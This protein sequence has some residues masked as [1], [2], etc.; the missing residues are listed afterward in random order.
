MKV[1]LLF[2]A[3]LVLDIASKCHIVA[4]MTEG[5][6]IPVV[7]GVFH[8]TYILNA[9][10]AFGILENQRAVFIGAASLLLIMFA[11]FFRYILTQPFLFQAGAALMTGG[12]LGN[13]ID[14][15]MVGKVID[16]LDFRIWP[17]FNIADIAICVGAGCIIWTMIKTKE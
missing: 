1:I 7:D 14:R 11:W 3:V 16:F 2:F 12:A 9:G 17:V 8:I 15:V 10:A 13:L 5:M 6:S 4:N